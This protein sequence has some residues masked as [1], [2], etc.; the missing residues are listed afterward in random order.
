MKMERSS[1]VNPTSERKTFLSKPVTSQVHMAETVDK[2]KRLLFSDKKKPTDKTK[3]KRK[4]PR[5][6]KR[7]ASNKRLANMLTAKAKEL[8]RSSVS[9][10]SSFNEI[11]ARMLELEVL[12]EKT[13][14]KVFFSVPLFN[15]IDAFRLLDYKKNAFLTYEELNERLVE[16]GIDLSKESSLLIAARLDV[17]NQGVIRY[18]DF[19]QELAMKHP[20]SANEIV[21]RPPMERE[22]AKKFK[23]DLKVILREFFRMLIRVEEDLELI[24]KNEL[25]I[26]NLDEVWSLISHEKKSPIKEV[27]LEDVFLSVGIDKMN[28]GLKARILADKLRVDRAATV[29]KENFIQEFATKLV[30]SES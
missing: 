12:L 25:M 16:L 28:D 26:F 4:R 29:L 1:S 19:C 2:A 15:N 24:R 13:K 17:E 18:S 8:S 11:L 30:R 22:E 7:S 14:E 21:N 10:L 20:E 9:N 3:G 5:S 23:K 6:S 27:P